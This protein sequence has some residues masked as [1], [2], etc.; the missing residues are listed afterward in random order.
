[1]LE[2]EFI[3]FQ[4]NELQA[5]QLKENE[6]ETLENELKLVTKAEEIKTNC[7][8]VLSLFKETRACWIK[9]R[10]AFPVK[11]SSGQCQF[12]INLRTIG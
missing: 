10:R 9:P 6:L 8:Q 5:A 7:M 2:K 4:W 1:M 11:E 3:E 12:K